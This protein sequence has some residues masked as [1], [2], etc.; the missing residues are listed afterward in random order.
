M[1][2]DMIVICAR[3]I[4][5]VLNW[6]QPDNVGAGREEVLAARSCISAWQ[7][8]DPLDFSSGERLGNLSYFSYWHCLFAHF[9]DLN[10]VLAGKH[11]CYAKEE[12]FL[13]I[14]FVLVE[15]LLFLMGHVG[16]GV[17]LS[18]DVLLVW[19]VQGVNGQMRVVIDDHFVFLGSDLIRY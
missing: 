9:D 15:L 2:F 5:L 11:A 8:G 13:L 17:F 10:G 4:W 1:Q 6:V 7:I 16:L 14:A 3:L 19:E 18:G 12:T